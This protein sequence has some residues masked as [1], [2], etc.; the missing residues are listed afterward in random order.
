M[1]SVLKIARHELSRLSYRLC[2]G[3]RQGRDTDKGQ[4]YNL[5]T[6]RGRFSRGVTSRIDRGER[7]KRRDFTRALS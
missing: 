2:L 1:A 3:R 4:P 5:A 7:E 6:A